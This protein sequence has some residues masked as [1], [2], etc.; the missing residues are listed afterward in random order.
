MA[1]LTI[2]GAMRTTPTAAL[3]V[4]L[5]L[6]PLHLVL[7][8]R[9]RSCA[10]RLA[11]VDSWGC[12]NQSAY[13]CELTKL[14]QKNKNY[15]SNP[16]KI[17]GKYNFQRLFD[18]IINDRDTQ[19]DF[20]N[21][22]SD[23]IIWYT[24]GSKNDEGAGFGVYCLDPHI[25]IKI[26]LEKHTTIYQAELLAINNC[27]ETC[28]GRHLNSK[29]IYICSDSQAALKSLQLN[30]IKS[31]TVNKCLENI[32][33]LGQNNNLKLVWVPGHSGILGNEKA[34]ELAKSAVSCHPL[35]SA[36]FMETLW[37]QDVKRW[38]QL[39]HKIY[40]RSSEGMKISKSFFPT[41]DNQR[42]HDL[43]NLN[44]NDLR[45]LIGIFTGHCPLNMH[46]NKLGIVSNP[47]CRFCDTTYETSIHF[48]S[49]CNALSS[50]RLKHF[51][52]AFPLIQQ[53]PKLKSKSLINY[54][55]DLGIPEFFNNY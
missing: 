54:F 48:I 26:G 8:A 21:V 50:K 28:L 40:W 46:L 17:I 2:T 16:D 33:Q 39:K 20:N 35:H 12:W 44:R 53:L 51:G 23:A 1:T 3:D 29:N 38:L 31:K 7:E 13:H 14:L 42:S 10:I 25:E 24:D 37:K 22:A 4:M 47:N 45:I 6:P 49:E 43:I 5:G 52:E 18:T 36:P 15:W 19:F 41:L 11:T 9:A 55:K 30:K 27:A 32:N 34:D